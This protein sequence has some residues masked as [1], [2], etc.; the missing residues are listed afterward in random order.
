MKTFSLCGS[1]ATKKQSSFDNS[2][3]P[4]D[5]LFENWNYNYHIS[6]NDNDNNNNW[7]SD[8]HVGSGKSDLCN[9]L[10]SSNSSPDDETQWGKRMIEWRTTYVKPL[11][12][13][14]TARSKPIVLEECKRME[15]HYKTAGNIQV[16]DPDEDIVSKAKFTTFKITLILFTS[17]LTFF[18][19]LCM[20]R[21]EN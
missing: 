13:Q 18:I 10:V 8:I 5:I 4:S 11:M 1:I 17:V 3:K 6:T 19:S 16:A 12:D 21:F 14:K 7:D 15:Q 20:L 2:R 9:Q